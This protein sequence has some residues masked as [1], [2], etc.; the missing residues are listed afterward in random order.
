MLGLLG[1]RVAQSPDRNPDILS[2]FEHSG[3]QKSRIPTIVPTNCRDSNITLA[4]N[5]LNRDI[6]RDKVSREY[7][8][9][10]PEQAIAPR[11]AP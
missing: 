4:L 3:G 9:V 6:P 5:N 1:L 8:G 10:G 2:G 7:G 11:I